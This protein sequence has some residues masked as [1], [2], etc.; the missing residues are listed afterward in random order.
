LAE[1]KK[2]IKQRKERGNKYRT[3]EHGIP[4]DEVFR[5]IILFSF[6]AAGE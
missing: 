6:Q 2:R 5:F 1:R 4:N 3:D